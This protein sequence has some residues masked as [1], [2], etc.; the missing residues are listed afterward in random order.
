MSE[1][2]TPPV[3]EA[4]CGTLF[5]M[6]LSLWPAGVH[7][8]H[9]GKSGPGALRWFSLTGS[10]RA[11]SYVAVVALIVVTFFLLN[12]LTWSLVRLFHRRSGSGRFGSGLL[13]N[14][15]FLWAMDWVLSV[16]VVAVLFV[17]SRKL[18]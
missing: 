9:F 4:G 14:M 1:S 16:A 10:Q 2:V 12:L 6:F 17:V 7:I 18:L 3:R 5:K 15:A 13:G 11:L 8:F